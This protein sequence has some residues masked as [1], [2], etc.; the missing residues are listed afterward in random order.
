MKPTAYHPET[1]KQILTAPLPAVHNAHLRREPRKTI[2][3][4]ARAL[5]KE[6]CIQHVSVTTPNYSMAQSINVRIPQAQPYEGAHEET[7]NRIDEETHA[8]KHWSG[9]A[10]AG[11][12][13]CKTSNMVRAKLESIL[14]AAFPD[15]GVVN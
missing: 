15:T 8:G 2:A 7:H 9:F 1:W 4:A 14:L 6:L 3:A 11:C 13:A 10:N 12:Q 5:L